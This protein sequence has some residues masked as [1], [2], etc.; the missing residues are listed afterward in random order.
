M[1]ETVAFVEYSDMA[2]VRLCLSKT[3]NADF[4]LRL[5][6]DGSYETVSPGE[7]V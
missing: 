2:N 4:E 5:R 3:K 1:E 6:N 7:S